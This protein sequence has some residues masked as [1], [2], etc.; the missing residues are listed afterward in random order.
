MPSSRIGY[1]YGPY[2][3][4]DFGTEGVI[5]T[6]SASVVV[7]SSVTANGGI[8]KDGF[9]SDSA[10]TSSITVSATRVRESGALVSSTAT[11]ASS[12]EEFVLKIIS[13][14]DYGDGAY[15]YGSYGQ[16][17]L[18]TTATASA[19]VTSAATK[20]FQG[21]AT[22]NASASATSSALTVVDGVATVSASSTNTAD[23]VATAGGSGTVTVSATFTCTASA[24]FIAA[25]I[26]ASESSFAAVAR[27]KWEPIPIAPETWV[28]I[29]S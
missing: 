24:T 26:T 22:A 7:T 17:P 4:A 11:N 14:Y 21:S 2:S 15:G 28:R 3:D 18:E 1:G 20:V 27:E 8:R 16:G 10:A 23:G 19:S 29:A 6:G 25:G 13:E 12:G 5:Q 9:A